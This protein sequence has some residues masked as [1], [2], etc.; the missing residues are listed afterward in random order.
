MPVPQTHTLT[1]TRPSG[2]GSNGH[3]PPE[4]GPPAGPTQ[5]GAGSHMQQH[6]GHHAL[7]KPSNDPSSQADPRMDGS[8]GAGMSLG[9]LP[10]VHSNATA[11][12]NIAALLPHLQAFSGGGM[13]SFSNTS[14][15]PPSS[16][17]LSPHD[18]RLHASL[19]T[20]A[21][22]N[23]KEGLTLNLN[24]APAA[25]LQGGQ[26]RKV[27]F[28]GECVPKREKWAGVGGRRHPGGWAEGWGD[29]EAKLACKLG[30]VPLP[31]HPLAAPSP[32]LF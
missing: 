32:G 12:G 28:S 22:V 10:N 14:G 29:Q 15:I 26:H 8:L 27:G 17:L 6:R 3:T 4:A 7:L 13:G 21:H 2:D 20:D 18:V 11:S 24:P 31:H 25:A 19:A 30:L 23:N 1:H 9:G 16:K 5:P